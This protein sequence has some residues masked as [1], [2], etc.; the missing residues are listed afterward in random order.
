MNKI[1][2]Y[3]RNI[4]KDIREDENSLKCRVFVFSSI[5]IFCISTIVQ[6][7]VI[8]ELLESVK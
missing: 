5:L 2:N 7:L 6:L 3:L 1:R 8:I 4:E